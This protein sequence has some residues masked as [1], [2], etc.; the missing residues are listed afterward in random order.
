MT[1]REILDKYI[2]VDNSRKSSRD[3]TSQL[4]LPSMEKVSFKSGLAKLFFAICMLR[5]LKAVTT[6]LSWVI[7]LLIS[8]TGL[9]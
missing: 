7:F 9:E 8:I 1:D 4:E 2:N 3:M 6:L 5:C